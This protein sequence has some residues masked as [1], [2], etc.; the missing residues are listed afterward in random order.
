MVNQMG[1]FSPRLAEVSQPLK[2][3]LSTK[4][5]WTWSPS[6]EQAFAQVKAELLKPTVL[7][8]YDPKA[9]TKVSADA[10]LFGLG[11]VLLPEDG[12]FLETCGL[13]ISISFR[14]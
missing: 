8:L 12:G 3:L 5:S 13:C 14:D 4:T 9:D 6:Q 2:E 7:A 1:K 11:A 10:S